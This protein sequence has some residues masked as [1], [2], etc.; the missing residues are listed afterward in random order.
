MPNKKDFNTVKIADNLGAT[1]GTFN[2]KLFSFVHNKFEI[3]KT[4][5]RRRED[6]WLECWAMYSGTPEAREIIKARM[7]RHVGNVNNDWR[8]NLSTG[9]G[10]EQ[11]ETILAYLQQ[12]FFPNRDWFDV[13]PLVPNIQDDA[14]T[15]K[16]FAKNKLI[17]AKFISHWEL[18]LRQLCITGTSILALPWRYETRKQK[19]RVRVFNNDDPENVS[20]SIKEEMRTVFNNHDFEVLDVFDVYFDPIAISVNDS[21]LVR[22][23]IKTRSE[24]AE[25]IQSG[26]YQNLTIKELQELPAYQPSDES[27]TNQSEISDYFGLEDRLQGQWNDK[28]ELYE[29]WGD[30]V[31]DNFVY[32]DTV[33]TWANGKILRFEN[34]PFWYGR[35][36]IVGSYTPI[37]RSIAALGVIEPA[38][39]MLH[40]LDILTNQRL[41]NLEL[42]ADTMWEK[43]DD[44][45]LNDEDVFTQ[46]GKVFNVSQINTIRP[47]ASAQNFTITYDEGI[48]LESRIDKNA[49]T[50]NLISANAARAGER[51]TAAEVNATRSAGGNRLSEIHKHI[52]QTSFLPLLDKIFRSYQ[53]FIVEDE[54]VRI[55]GQNPGDFDFV[56]VGPTELSNEMRFQPVG[57]DHIANREFEVNQ[58]L[59]F[60]QIAAQNPQMSERINYFNFMLD[61][62]R[63]MGID[64][65]EQFV[66]QQEPTPAPTA[67]TIRDQIAQTQGQTAANAVNAEFQADNGA[68]LLSEAFNINQQ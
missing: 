57:A 37:V 34:N 33:T 42:S 19:K 3:Y 29:Y 8:H 61:L 45:S 14:M 67:P 64:D 65:V 54:V 4:G 31:V 9:K 46:P 66:V 48:I 27:T 2:Q 16:N 30:A 38:L 43:V 56:A 23:V 63:R 1:S 62:A 22:R 60:L 17:E 41:D 55:P 44:G 32:K 49:G 5:R 10:F 68:R 36:F 25:S 52:E 53:Q 40:E 50:G 51:V 39:G 59:A 20:F 12:A 7:L 18:F 35:P 58:R 26:F 24:L 13:I 28:V 11:V 47:I 15:I 6:V 21:P